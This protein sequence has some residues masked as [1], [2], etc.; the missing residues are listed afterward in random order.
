MRTESKSIVISS[1]KADMLKDL[2]PP[3]KLDD[4]GYHEIAL[5]GLDMYHSIPNIDKDNN[6]FIYIYKGVSY[7]FYIEEGCYEINNINDYIQKKCAENDHADLF[8]IR[9]NANTLKCIIELKDPEVKIRF[10]SHRSLKSLL[11]FT[12]NTLEGVGEHVSANIVSILSVNA[13]LVHCNIIEGSYLNGVERPILY[14]FFPNVPPGYKIVEKPH[15]SIY[16]PVSYNSIDK[17]RLLLTDQDGNQL[18][19][20]DEEVT[21]R[22]HLRSCFSD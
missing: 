7:P 11:G 13:I 5:V 12:T 18:N 19:I 10:D 20:R 2:Y 17:L 4:K 3:I 9:A 1:R 15:S 14:T 21:I 22:L 8:E 16:L 6:K